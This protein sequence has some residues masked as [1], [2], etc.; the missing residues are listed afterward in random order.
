MSY[1]DYLQSPAKQEYVEFNRQL[2]EI[3]YSTGAFFFLDPHDALCGGGLCKNVD[4]HN[5]LLYADQGH[6]SK[7]GSREVIKAF[8]PQ[9]ERLRQEHCSLFSLPDR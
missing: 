5:H 1:V 8:L 6:L 9:L 3:A 7:Y 4:S 2:A